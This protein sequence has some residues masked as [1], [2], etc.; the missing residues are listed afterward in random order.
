MPT[1]PVPILEPITGEPILVPTTPVTIEFVQHC[2]DLSASFPAVITG[3]NAVVVIVAGTSDGNPVTVHP[4]TLNPLAPITPAGTFAVWDDGDSNCL[5]SP[6]GTINAG[7]Y[8]ISIWVLPSCP[9]QSNGLSVS[10]DSSLGYGWDA[11]E[12]SGLGGTPVVITQTAGS[13]GDGIAYDSGPIGTVNVNALIVGDSDCG[14]GIASRPGEPWTTYGTTTRGASWQIRDR[15]RPGLSMERHPDRRRG[16]GVGPSPRLS[17]AK[18]G[19]MPDRL[20][21]N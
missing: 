3:G 10:V 20:P 4:P 8:F 6:P 21:V 7:G 18:P 1:T 2:D 11:I 9:D 16:M 15:G 13:G 12:V 19:S 5:M 17:A 14:G